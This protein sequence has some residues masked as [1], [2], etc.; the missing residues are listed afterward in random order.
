MRPLGKYKV[1]ESNVDRM[2]LTA[3]VLVGERKWLWVA[4]RNDDMRIIVVAQ[5]F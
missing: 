3:A 5:L 4:I 2:K 1:H